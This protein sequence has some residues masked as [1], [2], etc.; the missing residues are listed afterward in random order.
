MN[1]RS[2]KKLKTDSAD[3]VPAPSA[4]KMTDTHILLPREAP[5]PEVVL[6]FRAVEYH[7]HAKNV[8][9]S[10]VIRKLMYSLSAAEEKGPPKGRKRPRDGQDGGDG[11]GDDESKEGE[12]QDAIGS[13][14][15]LPAVYRIE[16]DALLKKAG[17]KVT[18]QIFLL[19]L[20]YLHYPHSFLPLPPFWPTADMRDLMEKANDIE[21]LP[22]HAIWRPYASFDGKIDWDCFCL[23]L[24]KLFH[25]FDCRD[26]MAQTLLTVCQAAAPCSGKKAAKLYVWATQQELTDLAEV[27]LPIVLDDYTLE[28]EDWVT[29]WA[30]QGATLRQAQSAFV[31]VLNQLKGIKLEAQVKA[32]DEELRAEEAEEEADADLAPSPDPAQTPSEDEQKSVRTSLTYTALRFHLPFSPSSS[33]PPTCPALLFRSCCRPTHHRFLSFSSLSCATAVCSNGA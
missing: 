31:H 4:A 16:V 21:D 9:Q 28:H 29:E 8:S 19:F 22:Q 11:E 30:A 3:G 26:M 1:M 14:Q 32:D 5:S 27:A 13:A 25:F 10:G 2:S 7:V 24:L 12:A 23:P 18:K 33:C 6:V 17:I 20:Q 15:R